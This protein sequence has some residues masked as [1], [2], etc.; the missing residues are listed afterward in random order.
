MDLKRFV[1]NGHCLQK[2]HSPIL[3]ATQ[4]AGLNFWEKPERIDAHVGRNASTCSK[5]HQYLSRVGTLEEVLPI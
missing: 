1:L 4:V 5:L 2:R 3:R